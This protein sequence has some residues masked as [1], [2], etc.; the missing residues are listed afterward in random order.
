MLFRNWHK[1]LTVGLF[2]GEEDLVGRR[3]LASGRR[4]VE[5]QLRN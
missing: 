5:G 4:V 2:V 3:V 1:G